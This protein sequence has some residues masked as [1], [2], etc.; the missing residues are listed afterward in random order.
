P[1]TMTINTIP[2]LVEKVL[3]SNEHER[4]LLA[5]EQL[6]AR[7]E[8][9]PHRFQIYQLVPK[10]KTCIICQ[11]KL[12]EPEFD[13]ACI[14]IGR[15]NVYNG[16]LYKNECCDIIYKYGHMRNRRTR[17]RFVVSDAIFKQE[18]IHLFDHL[19]YE[20]IL[21]IGFTNLIQQAA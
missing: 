13:E 18:Y 7:F 6:Q 16:I 10:T 9:Q 11:I 17:E 2:E 5:I 12:K 8:L 19:I 1:N 3:L 21:I 4:L 20:R 15:N 14:I